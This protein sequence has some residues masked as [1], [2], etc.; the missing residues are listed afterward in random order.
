MKTLIFTF[1]LVAFVPFVVTA[2]TALVFFNEGIG[3]DPVQGIATTGSAVPNFVC[4]VPPGAAPWRIG[5]LQAEVD[6][7]GHITV[8]GRG[9]LLAGSKGI[10][11]NGGQTVQAVLFCISPANKCGTPSVTSPTGVPLAANGDFLIDD[12]LTPLPPLS[13]THPVLLITQVPANGGAW[14]AA[15]IQSPPP[16]PTPSPGPTPTPAFE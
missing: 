11:T 10:G 5:S 6:T 1:L 8:D 7:D 2:D 3:V 15:G 9:L 12:T 13:C 16:T 14:F 4:G